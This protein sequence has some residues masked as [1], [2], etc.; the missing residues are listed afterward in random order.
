[1]FEYPHVADIND[2]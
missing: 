2:R 1:M